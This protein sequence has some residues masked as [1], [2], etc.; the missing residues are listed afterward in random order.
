M[1]EGGGD[2]VFGCDGD[3]GGGC[4][5]DVCEGVGEGCACVVLGCVLIV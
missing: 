3:V 2:V 5:G 1:E 4:G